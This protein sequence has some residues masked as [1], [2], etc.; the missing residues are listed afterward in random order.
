MGDLSNTPELERLHYAL[1]D[2]IFKYF[3]SHCVAPGT[4][5]SIEFLNR[6]RDASLESFKQI[7]ETIG[8]TI[9]E[10]KEGDKYG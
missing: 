10:N 9:M 5:V 4:T 1:G 2:F 3:Q 6:V 7:M 8:Q